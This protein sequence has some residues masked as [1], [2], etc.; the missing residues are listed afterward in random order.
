[1]CYTLSGSSKHSQI[2]RLPGQQKQAAKKKGQ[3]KTASKPHA[4]KQGG[5]AKTKRELEA[6]ALAAA[7]ERR[8]KKRAR[9][10]SLVVAPP[11]AAAAAFGRA[12]GNQDALAAMRSHAAKK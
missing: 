1:M 11:A 3:G 7:M 2:A 8:E 5:V 12:T 10:R 9:G 4:P 6:A